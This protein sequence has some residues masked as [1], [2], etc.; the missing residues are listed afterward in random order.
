MYGAMRVPKDAL[1]SK[2]DFSLENLRNENVCWV[3]N[4]IN[5]LSPNSILSVLGRKYGK[6]K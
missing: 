4:A 1:F 6:E 3:L 5:N 2:T